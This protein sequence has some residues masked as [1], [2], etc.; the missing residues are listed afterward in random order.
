MTDTEP[1]YQPGDPVEYRMAGS[2]FVGILR[3][4]G[5]VGVGAF[6]DDRWP[7]AGTQP[8][9]ILRRWEPPART[10]T[11]GDTITTVADLDALPEGS[12]IGGLSIGGLSIGKSGTHVS[13]KAQGRNWCHTS[14]LVFQKIAITLPCR[15]LRVGGPT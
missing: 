8:V 2:S 7:E 9:V 1:T 10:F 15:V 4:D 12:V 6:D 14:G 11:V 13:V 5:W 3:P